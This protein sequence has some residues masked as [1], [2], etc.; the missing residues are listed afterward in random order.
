MISEL[1][2]DL[3]ELAEQVKKTNEILQ[4]PRCD[5]TDY[6]TTLERSLRVLRDHLNELLP[7]TPSEIWDPKREIRRHRSRHVCGND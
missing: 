4:N 3:T 7:M 5:D 1:L 2:G 6:H